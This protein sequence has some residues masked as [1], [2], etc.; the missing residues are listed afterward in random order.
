MTD[1]KHDETKDPS[2]A[3]LIEDLEP[4]AE[5]AESVKGGDGPTE[6]VSFNFGSIKYEY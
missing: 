2:E 6:S 1:E 5:D 4:D 3:D